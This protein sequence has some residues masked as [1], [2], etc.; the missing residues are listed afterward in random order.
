VPPLIIVE[1][2]C[3]GLERVLSG[4]A[5]EGWVVWHGWKLPVNPW[6]AE[7][8]RIVC[9]GRV[10]S[11]DDAAYALL[12]AARGAG[13]LVSIEHSDLL[14]RF[15][16][17]LSRLGRVEI[18][19]PSEPDE[20][21]ARLTPEQ[22]RLLELLSEGRSLGQAASELYISRRTADRRLASARACLGVRTTAE[23]AVIVHKSPSKT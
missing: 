10:V 9:T 14:E 20:R 15:Y 1:E 7:H 11:E 4:L 16:E 6:N 5:S 19:R 18:V 17:D 3:D 8:A 22:A 2:Q 12:A 21:I 23:A 13:V